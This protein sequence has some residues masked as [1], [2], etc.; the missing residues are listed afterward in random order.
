[1]QQRNNAVLA[2]CLVHTEF[3]IK[4]LDSWLIHFICTLKK[5]KI[6]YCGFMC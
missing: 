2:F 4:A 6:Q 1:M 5:K 3:N